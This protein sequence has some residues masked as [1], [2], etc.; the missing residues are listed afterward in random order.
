[1][2]RT[3]RSKLLP[4]PLKQMGKRLRR[5]GEKKVLIT[6]NRGLGD[7]ALGLWGI[8]K[9]LRTYQPDIEITYL[10]RAD[11]KEGF[12]LLENTQTIVS[13]GMR[14]GTSFNLDETLQKE[15][16]SKADF[17]LV[18]EKADPTRW[19]QKQLGVIKPVLRWKKEWDKFVD[20]FDL[21]KEETYVG[22]HVQTET[23]YNYEK[24]WPVENWH[25]LFSQL[26]GDHNVK[27]I[28]FGFQKDSHYNMEGVIDLRGETTLFEMLS[29]IKNRCR[30]LVLPDSGVLSLMYYIDAQFRVNVASLWADPNQGI[31]K[32][33]VVSPNKKW[34][35][36][37]LIGS[38]KDVSRVPVS[39]VVEALFQAGNKCD[40]EGIWNKRI[41]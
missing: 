37:V 35:H 33:N 17:D 16:Y 18:I 3:L 14:R 9:T 39:S 24:N 20:R 4:N 30:Y 23:V 12:E 34:E 13:S 5:N 11:L 1:M 27:V 6:W 28:L 29:I 7:I 41:F 2:F 19:L 10:T 21:S 36:T 32:Q 38:G 26:T 8:N 31:L 25:E 22:V 40:Q 15:G